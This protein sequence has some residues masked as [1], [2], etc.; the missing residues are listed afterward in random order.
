MG[1]SVRVGPGTRPKLSGYPTRNSCKI[2]TRTRPIKKFGY[3]DPTRIKFGSVPGTQKYPNYVLIVLFFK[4]KKNLIH[5]NKNLYP[6]FNIKMSNQHNNQHN[7]MYPSS[8]VSEKNHNSK[9][10][11]F[12]MR[13]NNFL[14]KYISNSILKNR[15]N[16]YI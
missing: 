6:N 14:I 15:N 10:H 4:K 11:K 5:L 9:V 1:L 3:P 2:S 13:I 8:K 12:T 16:Y 7:N